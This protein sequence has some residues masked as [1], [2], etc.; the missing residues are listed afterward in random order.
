[1]EITEIE[2]C[3]VCGSTSLEVIFDFG[4]Q[5]LSTRFP[6]PD[7][8]DAEQVPLTLTQC[9]H[10]KLVQLTHNYDLDDL[11][12]RGY[13][14][15]SGVN[16]TMRDHLGGIVTQL[17]NYADLKAGDTVLDI[18]S[19]DGT[20]LA[21]YREK[22]LNL[23]GIDPTVAQ[24]REYYPEGAHISPEFFTRDEFL[25][26]SPT[27][28]AKAISS[29]AVFYDVPDPARFV[30]EIASCLEAEGVWVM[31]QSYL[32]ILVSTL[33][34]DSICHEHL[35]Y[36][37]LKQIEIVAEQARLKVF[38]A[39]TN[40][41]NGGSIRAFLCHQNAHFKTETESLSR[42][43]ELE[44]AALL[45]D[46]E[47]FRSFHKRIMGLG[48]QLVDLLK[49]E[50]AAGKSIHIYGAS[51]KGNVLLQL[52]GIDASIV[53]AAAER[54]EWK[55]GHRTP[56][57]NIPIISEAES[58]AQKPDYYLVLPWHF[59]DEFVKREKEF[60]DNGGKLIFPLPEVEVYPS[61]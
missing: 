19:N 2:C 31:E 61:G 44:Q 12:R 16:Q 53:D 47:T 23:V 60:M 59:R 24:Y 50:K 37:C 21:A 48:D 34:F 9:Q 58:H 30:E 10:C 35:G 13:G 45:D 25:R 20:L 26:T 6:G 49:K 14:Y 33:S 18:A 52:F 43:R 42:L 5:A 57:T 17:E 54:N 29:I 15:R 56:G 51:T 39:E 4:V 41:M 28:S 8:P 1:M 46:P 40:D 11:Y 32:P 38:H 22:G 36:Y 7:D 27:P 3:R 55:F